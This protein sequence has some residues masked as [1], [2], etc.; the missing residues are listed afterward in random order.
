LQCDRHAELRT[1]EL[2]D[3]REPTR[4]D[5]A[6]I[7]RAESAFGVT[8][9]LFLVMICDRI[10]TWVWR[11][12]A[13]LHAEGHLPTEAVPHADRIISAARLVHV[14]GDTA[15]S[16]TFAGHDEYP[17]RDAAGTPLAG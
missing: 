13:E 8:E 5:G 12:P 17:Y 2:V 1:P 7:S 14:R 3:L 4:K 10:W 6:G 16:Q 9:T 15:C 11:D